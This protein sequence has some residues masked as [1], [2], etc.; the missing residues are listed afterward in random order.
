MQ[1]QGEMPCHQQGEKALLE[2]RKPLIA[3]DIP[4]SRIF[5][6][7]GLRE[8]RAGHPQRFSRPLVLLICV[9]RVAAVPGPRA[10]AAPEPAAKLARGAKPNRG[11]VREGQAIPSSGAVMR[12]GSTPAISFT[13]RLS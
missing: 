5:A 12:V 9:A 7:F 8:A 4:V 3:N 10:L 2:N 1:R 11:P 13:R 6:M